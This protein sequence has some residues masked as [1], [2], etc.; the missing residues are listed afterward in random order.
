MA[1][2]ETSSYL[3]NLID[4]ANAPIIVWNPDFKIIRFNHAF[5]HLTGRE[6]SEV[7]GERLDILFPAVSVQDSMAMIRRTSTGEHWESVEIPI[8]RVDG[9]IRT[10][11]WNS[12]TI[13]VPGTNKVFATIAQGQD[14][15]DR[16][17]V[18][19]ELVRSN[20]ELEQFAYVA[21]H[22]L[23]E[24]LR[25]ISGFLEL[26]S[27]RYEGKID[28]EADEFIRFAIDG[29]KRMN[30]LIEDLLQFS[31]IGRTA[32]KPELAS[33]ED[34]Y[35][36]AI[37]N[38]AVPIRDSGANITRGALP[39]LV[40]DRIQLTTLLQNLIGNAIKFHSDAPPRIEVQAKN[41]DGMWV[42]SVKD[43]GIGFPQEY[44]E[45]IFMMFERLHSKERY[46]GT[47]IGLA[48][49][50]KIVERHGGRIW[51][52]SRGGQGSTFYFS[53]PETSANLA[54]GPRNP[55]VE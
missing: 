23:K 36:E 51:A 22:D 54:P 9:R 18:E 50:K 31:R 47:G 16:K 14:I 24:P 13:Y 35:Q 46:P 39:T 10:V 53:I 20:A 5:E 52:E 26:L 42:F 33:I 8:Q 29:A 30:W 3:E 41:E 45:K 27:V 11:L 32:W 1:L 21:S 49:C 48:I 25:M 44:S 19:R 2:A 15:T 28:S 43:N 12:A 6:A 40:I 7:L 38:L 4:Y 37:R 55:T 17:D 34:A